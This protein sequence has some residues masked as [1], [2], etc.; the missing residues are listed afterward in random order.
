M[1]D[2]DRFQLRE[3]ESR[4]QKLIEMVHNVVLKD[5]QPDPKTINALSKLIADSDKSIIE[6]NKVLVE[7]NKGQT[8]EDVKNLALALI[9]ARAAEPNKKPVPVSNR[10]APTLPSEIGFDHPE[11]EKSLVNDPMN[12]ET[13]IAKMNAQKT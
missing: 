9:G 1:R 12:S 6:Q 10:E 7:E 11:G 4:R 2:E 13:F 3:N 8:L 5:E